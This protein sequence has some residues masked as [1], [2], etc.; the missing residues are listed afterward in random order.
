MNPYATLQRLEILEKAEVIE[1]GTG[2]MRA[3]E[4][5]HF[6]ESAS[7]PE[8]RDAW[9]ELLLQ[10]CHLD[11]LAMAIIWEHWQGG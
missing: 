6:G 4:E 5:M 8:V 7:M 1:E 10:Y 9:K 3:Y 11:T 2:A